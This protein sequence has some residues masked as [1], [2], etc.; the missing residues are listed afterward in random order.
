MKKHWRIW[1]MLAVAAMLMTGLGIPAISAQD[2]AP[3]REETFKVAINA[4]IDDPTNLNLYA[5]ASRSSTSRPR[6]CS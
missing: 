1:S 5:G 4:Q 6:C 3:T 2:S